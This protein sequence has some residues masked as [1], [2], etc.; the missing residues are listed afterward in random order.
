MRGSIDRWSAG[1]SG[2][3]AFAALLL[4]LLYW[5]REQATLARTALPSAAAVPPL[6]HVLAAHAACNASFCSRPHNASLDAALDAP[7][8]W[9]LRVAAAAPPPPRMPLGW[10]RVALALRT[11]AAHGG[12]VIVVR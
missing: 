9:Q 12:G 7:P 6:L 8:R 10:H 4:L 2:V 1:A 5:Q 3:V 11:L